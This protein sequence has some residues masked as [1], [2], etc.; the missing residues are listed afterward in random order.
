M[1]SG[2]ASRMAVQSRSANTAR[3]S[4]G[5]AGAVLGGSAAGHGSPHGARAESPSAAIASAA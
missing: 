5:S 1:S 3:L 2:R 4:W